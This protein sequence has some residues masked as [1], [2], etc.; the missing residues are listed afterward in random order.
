MKN[1]LALAVVALVCLGFAQCVFGADESPA[2][3]YANF[4]DKP[5]YDRFTIPWID[6]AN[7][8]EMQVVVDREAG[9]YLGHVTTVLLDDGK[10]ILCVYPKG[11][12]S[13]AIV[14][15]KSFDGGLTWSDRL[16][17][18]KNWETSMEVPTLFR[19]VDAQGQKRVLMFSGA[20]SKFMK[21][22]VV[23]IRMA[24]STDEG[25]TWSELEPIGNYAG[26]V[27]MG[28]LIPLRTGTGHY[29]A[30]YHLGANGEFHIWKV[31]S[32][33]GGV[34]W[35]Q[36]VS[37]CTNKRA[38]AHLCEP[39]VIRSPDGSQIAV[40]LRENAREFNSQ[41]IFSNDEGVTWSKPRPLPAALC[42]DRHTLRYTKDGRLFASFRDYPPKSMPSP[43]SGDWVGWVGTYQDL[44]DG[45]EGQY[46]LRLMRNTKSF[47][48]AYPGVVVLPDDTVVATTY[49]HWVQGESPYILTVRFK[50]SDVEKIAPPLA[51]SSIRSKVAKRPSRID[52]PPATLSDISCLS[53]TP[54]FEII[55]LF[56]H[57]K[58]RIPNLTITPKGT[59][60]A[61]TDSGHMVRTSRDDGKTWSKPISLNYSGGGS[62]IVDETTGDVLI[63]SGHGVLMRSR[64]D[65]ETWTQESITIR[66]N[67]AG[68][69][70]PDS[71]API[72]ISCSESGITLQHGEHKGRLL[73]PGRIMA[74]LGNNDQEHWMFHYNTSMFSDDHGKTWQV[75]HPVQSGTGEGTLAEFSDGIVYYNSRS[76]LSTDHRRQ[77]AYSH[78]GGDRYVDWEVCEDL[79]EVGEPFYFKYGTKPSYGCCAGLV[80]LPLSLTSGKDM[81]LFSAPDDPGG[82]RTHMTV[83]CSLDRSRSWQLKKLIYEKGCAYSSL[84]AAPNGMV[85]LLFEKGTDKGPYGKVSLARFNLSWFFGTEKGEMIDEKN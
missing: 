54:V 43:T 41:I 17:T 51:S 42:G 62:L 26:I 77:L 61:S 57:T 29:M 50:L 6:L 18:P 60:I 28:D 13:G 21:D 55:D 24:T 37:I 68:L 35:S 22:G 25:G 12:G 30:L 79:R 9:H 70:A 15:K 1:A 83:W 38:G 59:L 56:E 82:D 16:P 76:H 19:T 66:S 20:Q 23:P 34:T 78:D 52:P 31:L 40:L 73:M 58:T 3:L 4:P 65:G 74:P 5:G 32:K 81:L 80:R 85:Y 48:T 33:D 72:L 71:P 2:K 14:Y 36:P 75:S 53:E 63:V 39:G 64:D 84:A 7:H 11:H 67:L 8:P 27:A 45:N 69:G 49:G 46:R 10:T 47:D 44:V